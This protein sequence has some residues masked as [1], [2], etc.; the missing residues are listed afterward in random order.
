M[1]IVPSG[2]ST[3]Q[4]PPAQLGHQDADMLGKLLRV[5]E[6]KRPR[7][8]LRS[9]Y[10]DGKQPFKDF[11]IAVPDRLQEFD[12]TLEWP[13][14]GVSALVDRSNLEGFVAPGMTDDPFDIEG[15]LADNNFYAEFPMAVQSSAI[16]ACS[17]LTVSQG[18]V[19]AGEPE[20]LILPR[21]ADGSA[22]L[23]DKRRRG[24]RGFLSVIDADDD[25]QPTDLV[26]YLPDK[27]VLLTAANGR[28]HVSTRPNPLD[29]VPVAPL[30]HK[31]DLKRPFGKSRITRSAMYY[32]DAALRTIVR[33]EIH[34]EGFAGPQ[35]WIMGASA[36]SVV[37]NDRFKAVMGRVFGMT[38]NKDTGD[39][40]D[41]KRFDSSSPQP[42]T[43]HLRMWAT[44]FAGDQGMAVSSLGVVQDNP[45]SAEAIYA[46][47]EDL[48]T[49]ARMFNKSL[50]FGAAKAV[51]MAVRMRDGMSD[52]PDELRKLSA[53][54]TDPSMTSPTAAADAFTKRASV[55][56][57]FAESE[58]GLESA[59]LT[60]E[61]IVRF[62]DEQ[63]RNNAGSALQNLLAAAGNRSSSV[64]EA[65]ESVVPDV[66]VDSD[67]DE[68]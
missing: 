8:V 14:K 13:A 27:T 16:H 26:M 37:G 44:M 57:G 28:L 62:R 53:M 38:E 7:N 51:R 35:Y 59:G 68:G 42:H 19:A 9:V 39:I 50:G 23:W 46:A 12:Q 43:E 2:L 11:G 61:Q 20:I 54:F 65:A 1:T 49:D 45:S 58:V 64:E 3:Y 15:I 29:E 25:G 60:R 32:T 56:P 33:S 41:V 66:E 4:D 5:W 21:A 40:P 55:I 48:I 24:V 36:K 31:P 34:A 18:D 6:Q 63:R 67:A 22:G 17:F 30:V 10:Y 52:T 47:K